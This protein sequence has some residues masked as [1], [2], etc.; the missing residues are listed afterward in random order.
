M[1]KVMLSMFL[2]TQNA[3]DIMLK[4]HNRP[5][6]KSM[7]SKLELRLIPAKGRERIYKMES[8]SMKNEKDETSMLIKFVYPG[9]VK[10]TKFLLIEHKDREDDIWIYLPALRKAKK[11][12]ASGKKG[13]FMSSDFSNYDIGGG[14][15]EDWDYKLLEEKEYEGKEV[16]VI[17][18]TAKSRD[19]IKKTG[20]SKIIK[21]VL[22]DIPLTVYSEYYDK[23]GNLFKKITTDKYENIEGVWFETEMTAE[24]L[25][26]GHKSKFVF[27]EIETNVKL[28][29][30]Y[31]SPSYLK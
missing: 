27:T 3:K 7:K 25:K 30:K 18:C 16:Y 6:W 15:F 4:V 19:V 12:I 31:F 26:T 22:K 24:N 13:A 21:Y 11:I 28:P 8:Y 2:I 5:T 20:Y 9:D 17:E 29:K 14:E 10:G 1:I 23:S